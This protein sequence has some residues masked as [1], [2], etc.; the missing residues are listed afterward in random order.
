MDQPRV[1]EM[2]I[3]PPHSARPQ[4]AAAALASAAV[5]L[6]ALLVAGCAVGPDYH[7]P[8]VR[9]P[10]HYAAVPDAH[11]TANPGP[12]P[13]PVALASWWRALNDSELDSLIERAVRGNPDVLIALDRLQAART[14]EAGLIGTALPEVDASAAYGRGTG[15][16]VTSGRASEPLE[17]AD[18]SH[19]LTQ[20]NEIG[21]FDAVW[22]IDVFG[23]IRREIEAARDSAQAALDARNAVL[24]AVIA[25]VARAY[26]DLRGVQ[27]QSSVLHAAIG[28]LEESYRIVSIRYQRGLTNELDVTLAARELATLEAQVAPVD[29]QV[30]AAQYTIA[31]L[32]GVYPEDMMQELSPP[33]M[34]PAVPA[35]V[36]T[37]LPLG[38]LE[39]RPDVMEAERLLAGSN[40]EIGVTTAMLFPQIIASGA[41]GFQRADLYSPP[42]VARHI[43]SAGA[44]VVWPLLDFGVLDAQVKIANLQTRAALENYKRLIESAVLQVDSAA[45]AYGAEQQSVKNLGD[46][47]VAS[48]RAVTLANARYNRGLTDFLN[49]VD[50]EREEY[51]IEEQ[52]V[53]AETAVAEQFVELYK[54]LGG[55][56]QGFQ[57][58]P[59][60]N[61]PLP[62]V[63]AIFRDTLGRSDALKDP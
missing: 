63:I 51:A 41:V 6:A 47:L 56:W 40:A 13:Q 31:T 15:H 14:Y 54:D 39:R 61:R 5:S 32:L 30:R 24:V 57:N 18:D 7:T 17:S 10:D 50:A 1:L 38:L 48:K 58:V 35:N 11:A 49:V 44:G 28:V 8:R 25:D 29:A 9:M 16:D 2:P 42:A 23:R 43:W 19:S 33:G 34:V 37:G 46:A 20:I 12:A 53:G 4:R 60:I 27:M 52:L 21:G 36:H 26:V 22:E 62:E 55:G 59:G 45:D 3:S